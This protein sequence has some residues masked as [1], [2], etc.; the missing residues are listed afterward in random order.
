MRR[1]ITAV[2]AIALSLPLSVAGPTPTAASTPFTDVADSPF[3]H[4]ITWAYENGL[5]AGC[6]TTAFCPGSMVTRE[7]MASFLDRMFRLK[8]TSRDYFSDDAT[9]Q[10][11]AAINRLAAAGITG[12][13]AEARYCPS[14]RVTREQMASFIARAARL[15]IGSGRNYF[16]DDDGRSHESNIDRLAAA[17]IGSGCGTWRFCPTSSVTREQMAAFLHRIVAPLRPPPY[18]APASSGAVVLV[19]AGDIAS[20]SNATDEATAKLLDTIA[21][22]VFTAGDNVYLDGKAAEFTKCYGPSWGRHRSRTR[23]APGNHDYHVSGAAGYFGYFGAAAGP[24]G[25]GYYAYA[26]GAW[27]VYSLNSDVITSAQ[28]A[29]LRSDLAAHPTRCVVAY[30]HHPRFATLNDNGSHGSNADTEPLW[31]ALAD[32]GAELV[33]NG[34]SHH[35]ERFGPIRGITEIVAGTG[36]AGLDGFSN[37]V[38]SNSVVRSSAAHGVVKLNLT[39]TGYTG[40]FVPVAGARFTDSFSGSCH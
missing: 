29:W 33:I 6:T 16:G 32:A 22:T 25:R 8:P 20:C 37:R 26:L 28:V 23:P 31:D 21:G 1:L 39:A 30:W 35:Y 2:A 9:S 17:G 12:G 27:R 7:Q 5:T 38:L 18:P 24:A 34:H 15:T 40:S 3:I 10:H 19:G 13:C 36:G 4:D 14:A 11:Q